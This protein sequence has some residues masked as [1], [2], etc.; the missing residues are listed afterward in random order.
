M[1]RLMKKLRVLTISHLFPSKE[2]KFSGIFICREAQQLAK[3]SIECDFLVPRPWAPLAFASI[4]EMARDFH[5][6]GT[7]SL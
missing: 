3:Y 7:K 4:A 6:Q 1:V 5:R 2:V